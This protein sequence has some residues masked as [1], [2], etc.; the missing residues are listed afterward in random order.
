VYIYILLKGIL[1]DK[2]SYS[3]NERQLSKTGKTRLELK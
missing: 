1:D 3:Q 2:L